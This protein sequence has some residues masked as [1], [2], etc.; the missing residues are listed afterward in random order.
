[1]Y[2]RRNLLQNNSFTHVFFRCH[3]RQFFFKDSTVKNFLLFLWAKYKKKYAIKIFEFAIMDNHAHLLVF[4]D[5]VQQ[6]GDFMRTVNSQL[7]RFINKRLNRDSQ[8]IRER[9]KSPLITNDIYLQ[10]T[11]QYIWMN[12]YKA[13][14]RRP[15]TDPYC[16]ASWRIQPE[17]YKVISKTKER[18]EMLSCLIDSYELLPI[19]IGIPIRRFVMDLL[20]A[21][22]SKM[23]EL[24]SEVFENSHTIG[25][26][27]SV[28]FRGEQLSAFRRERVPWV[29]SP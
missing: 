6:L 29:W 3:N 13:T 9:Y 8:A 25:D 28:R 20:N 15:E 14:Q 16:S 7:A 11:M 21:A 5:S 19:V 2:A 27:E 26:Y 24:V 18:E 10:R 4:A 1:M 17:I 23:H 22:I 12:R